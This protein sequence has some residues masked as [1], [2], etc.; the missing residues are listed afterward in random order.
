[1][2]KCLFQVHKF[3]LPHTFKY[4]QEDKELVQCSP[5][6]MKTT[7]WFLCSIFGEWES[8]PRCFPTYVSDHS[9][10]RLIFLW[11]YRWWKVDIKSWIVFN[12]WGLKKL[13][14]GRRDWSLGVFPLLGVHWITL[15]LAPQPG[16]IL[17]W[18][19]LPGATKSPGIAGTHK[20]ISLFLHLP[21]GWKMK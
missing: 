13:I 2:I 19:S 16:Q 9:W 5:T 11:S 17:L 6:K 1:M 18:E 7:L 10:L 14:P 21:H 12:W 15:H 3:K 8:E 4:P 20:H